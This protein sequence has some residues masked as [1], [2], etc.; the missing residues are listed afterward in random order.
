MIDPNPSHLLIGGVPAVVFLPP[1]VSSAQSLSPS[2][3]NQSYGQITFNNF[4]F[5]ILTDSLTK[6]NFYATLNRKCLGR[7]VFRSFCILHL[8]WLQ[9]E[10]ERTESNLYKC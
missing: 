1:P 10:S 5:L 6:A 2:L 4:F 7:A 9:F 3:L 8:P